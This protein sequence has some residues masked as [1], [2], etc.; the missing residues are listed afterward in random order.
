MLPLS[1][2][3]QYTV[4]QLVGFVSERMKADQHAYVG[5]AG[6]GP[7]S[8]HSGYIYREMRSDTELVHLSWDFLRTEELQYSK[9]PP[10][11]LTINRVI[12]PGSGL[13]PSTPARQTL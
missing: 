11:T 12:P 13:P 1:A 7:F 5:G 2:L 6:V 10:A 8:S 4:A 3:H 9:L